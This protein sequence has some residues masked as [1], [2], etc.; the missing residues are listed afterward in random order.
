MKDAIQAVVPEN[1]NDSDVQAAYQIARLIRNA[2]AH[3]PFSPKWLIDAKYRNKVFVIPGVMAFDTK[4]FDGTEFDWRQYGGPLALFRLCQWVRFR[5][6][7]DD[8]TPRKVVPLP[9]NVVY[10]QGD[11]I[12]HKVNEIPANATRVEKLSEGEVSLGGGHVI[13][14]ADKE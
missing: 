10:Q 2:F 7:K 14:P 5:I 9:G 11:L 13:R 12:L 4:G 8:M 1:S 3:A 6:L